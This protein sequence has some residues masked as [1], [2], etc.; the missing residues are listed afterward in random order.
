MSMKKI[1][2]E[3]EDPQGTGERDLIISV[4]SYAV[5]D[6]LNLGFSSDVQAHDHRQAEA[7]IESRS[8]GAFSFEWICQHLNFDS[9]VLRPLLFKKFRDGVRW[10][11]ERE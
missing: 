5:R 6:Y 10:E 4:F 11:V 3:P 8:M 9:R 7:W 1:E 2:L